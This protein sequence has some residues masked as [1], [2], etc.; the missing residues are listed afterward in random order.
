MDVIATPTGGGQAVPLGSIAEGIW[1]KGFRSNAS[2]SLEAMLFASAL[3]P[4]VFDHVGTN[5]Q[6]SFAAGRS[7]DDAGKALLHLATHP[8]QVPRRCTLKFTQFQ[9][10]VWLTGC[11]IARIDLVDKSGAYIAFGY[12]IIG[13]QWTTQQPVT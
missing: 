5:R 2:R 8:D 11:G 1:V 12:D 10:S 7:F 13:G 6:F 9:K 4:V 3:S